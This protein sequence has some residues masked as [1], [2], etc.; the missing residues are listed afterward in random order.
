MSIEGTESPNGVVSQSIWDSIAC[1]RPS[2]G[3]WFLL[4]ACLGLAGCG[5]GNGGS[6]ASAGSG[7]G[8]SGGGSS[9]GGPGEPPF[10]LTSREPVAPLNIPLGGGALGSYEPEESFP[11]L[12]FPAAVFLAAVP[13]ENR[14]VVV[15][16]TGFVRV[17]DDDPG[18]TTSSLVLD[19]S[20]VV[21][22]SG[23]EM[24][25][26]GLAFDPDFP[27]NRYFYVH[28]SIGGPHRSRIARYTWDA[29]TDQATPGSLK[30]IL[31]VP[32]P[33]ANHNAGMLAFGPDDY[34]YIALGDGGSSNDPGN[35]AQ[36]TTELLGSMLRV[37]VHPANPADGYDIPP[38]NPFLGQAGY[39][40]EIW[41]YGLRNP[42]RFS[43]DRGTGRLWAGDVGQT[44]REEVDVIV[45]G[46][47]YGWRIYEGGI[48]NPNLSDPNPDNIPPE[49]LEPPVIDY[50][51][52]RA[53]R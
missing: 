30:V 40:P 3:F 10:G 18:A 13:G 24:G 15:Q 47:N 11:F 28:Y 37:D 22:T 50:P 31:D 8:S 16:Q 20:S 32:Q 53:A 7:S 42:W 44:A 17:F 45:P 49:D 19:L 25:L 34:L 36:D 43:F 46:G 9:G 48:L 12:D 4:L 27:T 51:V 6:L 2:I 41:A 29:G 33:Y 35:R 26:L 21:D 14:L 52:P 38:D 5:G 23:F 39:L 1:M